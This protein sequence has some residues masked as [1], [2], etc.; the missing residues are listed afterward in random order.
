MA[1]KPGMGGQI[2]IAARLGQKQSEEPKARIGDSP[3]VI[4]REPTDIATR[5]LFYGPGGFKHLPAGKLA[6]TQEKLNGVNPKFDVRDEDNV[7]WGVKMGVEAKP[8][9]AATRLMW[10]VGYF[11]N[12]D[13]YLPVLNVS[14]DMPLTRGKDLIKHG[15]IDGARL[16]RHNKGEREIGNWSWDVNPFVNTRELN[17][18]KIMMEIIC[19]TDLK[20]AQQHV[21]DEHGIEQRYIAADVGASFGR[22]GKTLFRTKGNLRDYQAEPLIKGIG[23]DYVDFW[24]FKHIP[25]EHAKWIGGYLNQLTDAQIRDAFRAGG[26]SPAEIDGF[27]IKVR[28]KINELNQL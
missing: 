28:D 19:N 16:K 4:W 11:A 3:A 17:G 22:A 6:F 8:E 2:A 7:R 18:L 9:T 15:K 10:A 1:P 20:K 25:R 13:Y 21:Y 5:D 12:E 26:F 23:P 27:A 24:V 14:G